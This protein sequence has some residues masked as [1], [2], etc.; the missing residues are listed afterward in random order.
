MK[1]SFLSSLLLGVFFVTSIGM[2]TSCKDYDDDI[3]TN[4]NAITKLQEQV[5]TLKSALDQAQKD[6]TAAHAKFVEKQ[7]L[8][9]ALANSEAYKALQAEMKSLVKAD[10]LS[11]AIADCEEAIAKK[12]VTTEQLTALATKVDGIDGTLNKLGTTLNSLETAVKA[13]EANLAAQ[14]LAF[15]KLGDAIKNLQGKADQDFVLAEIAKLKAEL[16]GTSVGDVASIS[17][18]KKAMKKLDEKVATFGGDINMLTVLLSKRLTSIMLKPDFY[19]EGLAGIEMPWA[20]PLV[21]VKDGKRTFSYKIPASQGWETVTATVAE[22]LKLSQKRVIISNGAIAR[23]HM[24]PTTANLEG[25]Q[26]SFFTNE[27]NVYTRAGEAFVAPM[28]PKFKAG[29][30]NKVENGILSVPFKVN[31]VD[32]LMGMYKSWW[33]QNST[34]PV[35]NNNMWDDDEDN[36]SYG[37][38]LPFIALQTH[39]GDTTVTSDYAAL[40]PAK[41]T[42]V[43]LADNEPDEILDQGTFIKQDNGKVG[44][45]H[46][47]TALYGVNGEQ[48]GKTLADAETHG[49][50]TMPATHAVVYTDTIDLE[51]FIETHFDYQTWAQYGKAHHDN[52]MSKQQMAVLGL[53]YEFTPI[54]WVKGKNKTSETVH[55]QQIGDKKSGKFAPRSVT[56]DG[57]Q[58]KDK[59]ATGEVVD[60]EPLVRV[61][62]VDAKGNIILYGYIKI[63]IVK[64]PLKDT[65]V[66][67]NLS[68]YWMNCGDEGAL[69]W[70]QVEAGI[71]RKLGGISKQDFERMY[72]FEAVNGKDFMP[73]E[74]DGRLYTDLWYGVRY[75][76]ADVTT[77]VPDADTFGRVWYTPHDNNTD[78]H[79]WDN[80]TNV[81]LWNL[82]PA[83]ATHEGN[84]NADKYEQLMKAANVT[85]ASKGLN[86]KAV[87]TW[88]RFIN[89]ENKTS[90]W[91]HL[92]I[93]V[94]KLHFEYG[95][96]GNKV[97]RHWYF[98]NSHNAIPEA[99]RDEAFDVHANLPTPSEST[100][101]TELP[102]N[103]FD[104]DLRELWLKE[105]LIPTLEGDASKFTK[106]YDASK[107]VLTTVDFEFTTPV[108]GVNSKNVSATNGSWNVKGA[109]GSVWTLKLS[110]DKHIIWA[111]QQNGKLLANPE[112]VAELRMNPDNTSY[113]V[114]HYFGEEGIN[115]NAA[116]DL[117]NLMGYRDNTGKVIE[118]TY[119]DDNI[120]KTFTAY[121]KVIFSKDPCYAPR[122]GNNLF[123]VRFLRPISVWPVH[124]TWKDA[125]NQVEK[126]NLEDMVKIVDWRNYEVKVNANFSEGEI[127]YKYY[128]ISDL[129]VIREEIRTD[130]YYGIDVREGA[131]LTNPADIMKLQQ[132]DEIPSLTAYQ[133][134]DGITTATYFKL[135]NGNDKEVHNSVKLGHGPGGIWTNGK[136]DH[137][138][139]GRVEYVNNGT[140]SQMFHIYVP[141]AVRYNWGNVQY[142]ETDKNTSGVQKNLD[143]TQKVWVC[144]TIGKTVNHSGQAK[145]K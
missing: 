30:L 104:K 6:A 32:K 92:T 74:A 139:F 9:T 103:K 87:D 117:L 93:P 137:K 135:Y 14:G 25:A 2:L 116:T 27:A 75:T 76:K 29:G 80:Q 69:T 122:I 33:K 109:S 107:N 3:S 88:V 78:T 36:T 64:S 24:N 102:A 131:P 4:T 115:T 86:K 68:D 144:I 47:Y 20:D 21:Y 91:V 136:G 90:V 129:A 49:V 23:Y 57:V 79:A 60:R 1:K 5:T 73:T 141:I 119:L 106:F 40:T 62:L 124:V 55:I 123:N 113:S 67:F 39:V 66:E 11:K 65:I 43:A 70:S 37:E 140:T 110:A 44:Q 121:L 54:D 96:I 17:D 114:V 134:N 97:L 125:L 77:K 89:K 120:D 142:K 15:D 31:D 132:L 100:I 8:S 82:Q 133:K 19:W 108:K 50:I 41:Y 118:S 128:G 112:K 101:T 145:G 53:H 42:F 22:H 59:Q 84:M 61:D 138:S 46:L 58:I 85:Y 94:D 71:L 38:K 7:E 48:F 10:Q 72:Y 98:F 13:A 45:N 34:D 18:L 12:Y 99:K 83:S 127:P 143:Y 111:M 126:K 28:E 56:E 52:V 130:A 16:T 105:G 26:F 81:L 63:R 95:K 35:E 51:P